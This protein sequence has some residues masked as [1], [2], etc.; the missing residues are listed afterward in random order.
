MQLESEGA[1]VPLTAAGPAQSHAGGLGKFDFNCAKGY[2]LA[3]YLSIFHIKFSA[4]WR[5][6]V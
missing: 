2:R 6:F 1:K 5:I 3:Y 4:A